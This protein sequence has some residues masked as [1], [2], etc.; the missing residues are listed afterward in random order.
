LD[1]LPELFSPDPDKQELSFLTSLVDVIR[2]TYGQLGP[3]LAI[4][5]QT[6]RVALCLETNKLS[7]GLSA[8]RV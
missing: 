3:A 4:G 6:H 5:N 7:G 2:A 8:K 1:V